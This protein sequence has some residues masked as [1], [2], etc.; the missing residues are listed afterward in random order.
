MVNILQY[1][2]AWLSLAWLGL[3]LFACN[4]SA[5]NITAKLSR[6]PVLLDESFHLVYEADSNVDDPD[7]SA[8]DKDFE[9]L[10]SSQ[11]TN[12]RSINGSWS[13][14]KSWDLALISKQVG[15]FTIPPI[16]FGN[17]SSPALRVTV[18]PPSAATPPPRAGAPD[19]G[20]AVD[21]AN[22]NIY[23]EVETDVKQAW[24]QSQIIYTVRLYSNVPV[25]RPTLSK[26][27]TS[28]GDTIFLPLG[29]INNY[30]S[31]RNGQRYAVSELKYAAFPQHSGTLRFDPAIFEGVVGVGRS[32]SIFDT[33][34]QRGTV[35]RVRSNALEVE[36]KPLPAAQNSNHW[37]PAKQLTLLDEWS[38]DI[39]QLKTGEPVTRTITLL[40]KGLS[41]EQLPD[42]KPQEID[43]LKQYSD[44]PVN[45]N[46]H[47]VGGVS[48]SRQMK[49]ALIASRAGTFTLPAVRVPWWNTSTAKTEIAELPAVTITAT[50]AAN[51]QR[52]PPPAPLLQAPL[53]Q[54][55]ALSDN[56]DAATRKQNVLA[57]AT[58]SLVER[59][60]A[61]VWRWLS[62]ALGIGWLLTLI[63]LLRKRGTS[64][65]ATVSLASREKA[66]RTSCARHHASD[67]RQALLD[68]ANAK[69][70]Q[71]NIA[72]LIDIAQRT[73]PALA[74]AIR[75]LNVALYSNTH[76][77]WQG[78]TLGDA[79]MRY[80]DEVTPAAKPQATSSLEPL[81]KA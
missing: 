22:A 11:S 19:T 49:V 15:V 79:F 10:N 45:E 75:E 60:P 32:T 77:S 34:R 35:K 41:A 81:F 48:S 24:V 13:L 78:K 7:F 1:K 26:P 73:Q 9:I 59:I 62:L 51:T 31:F 43:G 25:G 4:S 72:N 37:L 80:R 54:A 29:D 27:S 40:A 63:A 56:G 28:D 8:L 20:N 36:V 61:T 50:G 66:V 30:E 71:A 14:K 74:T 47:D 55:P 2:R 6:D 23:I 76:T 21:G 58:T 65:A 39:T 44:Q 70:P 57:S 5:A 17:D 46:T 53:S 52:N 67:T 69:W 12:M 42:I 18:K 38:E 33:F 68:W 64:T 3:L 16:P